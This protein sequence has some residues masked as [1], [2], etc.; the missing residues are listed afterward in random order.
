[1]ISDDYQKQPK[2]SPPKMGDWWKLAKLNRTM[3]DRH[4]RVGVT[5]NSEYGNH[6][7]KSPREPKMIVHNSHVGA[8]LH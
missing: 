2:D 3:D 4:P 8:H 1:M 6:P 5:M 7:P